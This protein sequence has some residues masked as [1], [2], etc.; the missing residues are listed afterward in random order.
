[1]EW[2]V[3]KKLRSLVTGLEGA[4]PSADLTFELLEP[5]AA[6]PGAVLKP[7]LLGPTRTLCFMGLGW[8]P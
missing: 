4:A 6:S 5:V 7:Q 1:M 3:I 8:V 2:R